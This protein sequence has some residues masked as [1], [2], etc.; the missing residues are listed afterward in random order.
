MS[1]RPT[2]DADERKRALGEKGIQQAAERRAR[3]TGKPASEVR[4]ELE[5][6]LQGRMYKVATESM[7]GAPFFRIDMFG[8]TKMLFLN[9]AHRF[10]R[11]VHSGQNSTPEVRS[12]LEILLFAIG[13]RVLETSGTCGTCT[14]TR[15]RSGRRSST[16]PSRSWAK[17]CTIPT[18]KSVT[19]PMGTCRRRNE[20]ST[21]WLH[22][23]R[24]LLG[25][26]CIKKEPIDACEK[27]GN[28][29]AGP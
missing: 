10:Y 24:P 14:A 20:P 19:E 17:R 28:F 7:P 21:Q 2:P 8:G 13:D 3:E 1:P 25:P 29:T 9:T 15:S 22:W 6:E 4:K 26:I 12:A 16:M 23:D 5:F 27:R 18:R 11:D